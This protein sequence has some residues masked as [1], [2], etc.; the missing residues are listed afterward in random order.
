MTLAD[1]SGIRANAEEYLTDSC[2]ITAD[3]EGRGDA[4]FDETTGR[5]T[6]PDPD[7]TVVYA[8][9]CLF[10]VEDPDRVTGEGGREV[11]R[12]EN[13]LRV[14]VSATGITEGNTVRCTGVGPDGDPDLVDKSFSVTKVDRR[15]NV[16]LRHVGLEYRR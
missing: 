8:G 15:S 6:H 3:P 16:A 2:V 9:P 11:R 13:R 4:T 12:R 5:V 10:G 7:T 14:P 1:L